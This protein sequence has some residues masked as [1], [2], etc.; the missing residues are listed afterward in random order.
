MKTIKKY[1][2]TYILPT[3]E[4]LEES[5]KPSLYERLKLWLNK[6]LDL[7][8]AKIDK[9]IVYQY[10]DYMNTAYDTTPDERDITFWE[11]ASWTDD[12]LQRRVLLS[13]W[14]ILNQWKTLLCVAYAWTNCVN[15][16]A[17]FVKEE[18]NKD[19]VVLAKYIKNNLDS[20][21][22]ER[23]T[24]IINW[25][26]WAKALGWI[27]WYTQTS[28]KDIKKALNNWLAIETWTN[29]VS[30]RKTRKNA[31]AVL[32]QGWWHAISIVWYDDDLTRADWYW[33]VYT[34]FYIIENSWGEKWWD[35][36]RYY[37]PYELAEKIFFILLFEVLLIGQIQEY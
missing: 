26:K 20:K 37:I 28:I 29:K 1:G 32:W 18:Y 33:K 6:N 34:W 8:L 21:I 5:T 3:K 4:E 30:W 25:A 17:K 35:E 9:K 14:K 10:D 7:W 31:V 12:K 23:W 2:R 22:Y 15:E 24:Y 16:S 36:W 11:I 27:E 19:P 13:D